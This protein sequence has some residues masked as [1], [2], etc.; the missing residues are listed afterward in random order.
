MS[1]SL[2]NR[3]SIVPTCFI[4]L[5]IL[6]SSPAFA[7]SVSKRF[8]DFYGGL[9]HPLTAMEHLLPIIGLSLLAGQTGKEAARW[10]LLLFP[11]AFLVGATPSSIDVPVEFVVWANRISFVVVGLLVA[12]SIRLPV[13][14]LIMIAML[15]GILLGY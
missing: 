10:V 5:T 8:G 6:L 3:R 15:M 9:L 1:R 13:G 12:A 14:V 4:A 11:V 7:H 2:I